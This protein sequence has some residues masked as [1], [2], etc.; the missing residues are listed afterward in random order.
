MTGIAPFIL[1][2]TL[3]G[4]PAVIHV[5]D[6]RRD[7][8]EVQL[9]F[10]FVIL[11]QVGQASSLSNGETRYANCIGIS[12]VSRPDPLALPDAER[13]AAL[14]SVATAYVEQAQAAHDEE[15]G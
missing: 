2:T 1:E 12:T 5:R 13:D 14:I 15:V 4:R 9:S 11:D 8:F 7:L 6:H 3:N 10:E